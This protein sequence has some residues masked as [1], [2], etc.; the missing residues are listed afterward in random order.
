MGAP[1]G[2]PIGWGAPPNSVS[3]QG[4]GSPFEVP[5]DG[6]TAPVGPPQKQT[7]PKAIWQA[8]SFPRKATVILVLPLIAAS[9]VILTEKPL[10]PKPPKTST[11]ATTTAPKP[12]TVTAAAAPPTAA[13]ATTASAD[14]AP[15]AGPVEDKQAK[16]SKTAD[17]DAKLPP[18]KLS[19]QREAADAV[20]AGAYDRAA[21]MYEELAAKYPDQAVFSEAAAI[22]RAKANSRNK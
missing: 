15:G 22:T 13:T 3:P 17:E 4:T 2:G 8:M 7:G 6:A 10:P 20:A 16:R 5:G 19:A 18:G 1:P 12:S 21:K 9:F 11:S 14:P